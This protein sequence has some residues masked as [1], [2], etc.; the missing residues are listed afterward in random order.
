QLFP[1]TTLF[2]SESWNAESLADEKLANEMADAETVKWANENKE[3][4]MKNKAKDFPDAHKEA[5]EGMWNKEV[6]NKRVE[7]LDKA[8]E[9][10]GTVKKN[11]GN[12][13]NA[14]QLAI[15]VTE[16]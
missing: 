3:D 4:F 11:E 5:L 7:L 13:A 15:A 2:R 9:T 14:D 16:K 1:Y 12:Y 8:R 10:I 6:S